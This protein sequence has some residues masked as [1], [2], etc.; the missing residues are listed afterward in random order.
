MGMSFSYSL[1]AIGTLYRDYLR[2]MEHID[3]VQP[4]AV[5]RSPSSEQVRPC[6]LGR[7]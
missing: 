4:G 1:E 3:R 6:S 5:H 7:H 2:M